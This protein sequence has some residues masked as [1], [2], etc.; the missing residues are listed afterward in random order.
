VTQVTA[1]ERSLENEFL[2]VT[3]NDHGEISSIWDKEAGRE[4]ATG[5]CNS[6]RM[7]K[8]VPTHWD[9]WDLDSMY[10]LTPVALDEAAEIS[11]IAQGPLV[12]MVE[13]RRQLNLSPMVQ[14]ISL[15]RGSRRIEFDTEIDWQETHKMLKVAFPVSVYAHE[16]VHEIQ[17]GH[18]RRPNHLS[19]PFDADRFEVANH[20]WTALVEEGRGCAVLNDC[21]YGVNVLG[22]TIMLTLLK[23]ALAPDMYADKGLQEFSYALYAWN[24][25]F[26]DS[27]VVREA[28]E[29]NCPV[30]T[31]SGGAGERS[32][33]QVSAPN[34]VIET[35]KLAEDGSGDIVVRLYEAK[36]T[37]TRCTL[38]VDL[39]LAS[40]EL[41]D[42]LEEN[43]R[44]LHV[45]QGAVT[46]DLR[47]FEIATLRL[48]IGS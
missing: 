33:F 46:L 6:L 27:D 37:A 38:H 9:A 18:I 23:S 30:M 24:G 45:D 2:R 48:K 19:R 17:F 28:Y 13:V 35:V 36:R 11:V 47:P 20:K 32:V 8:D 10:A 15:R 43:A 4:L 25:S 16:A 42:M 12:G 26:I 29:M 1:T 41:A 22:D 21:K 14:Q 34:V 40:A 7:Y 44:P 3:L 5:P 31:V 39:P